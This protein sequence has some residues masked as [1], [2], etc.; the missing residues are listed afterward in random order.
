MGKVHFP[1]FASWCSDARS[2]ML[3]FP[4]GAHDDFVDFMSHIGN[5]LL[6]ERGA[7]RLSTANDNVVRVGSPEWILRA[8]LRRGQQERREAASRGW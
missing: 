3:Q 7:S 1:R 4:H 8:S 5:G 6:Q 2:Q